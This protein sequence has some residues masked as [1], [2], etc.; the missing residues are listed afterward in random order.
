MSLKL[1]KEDARPCAV[2]LECAEGKCMWADLLFLEA[3]SDFVRGLVRSRTV[4]DGGRLVCG[5]LG[6]THPDMKQ[7]WLLVVISG[8]RDPRLSLRW[9]ER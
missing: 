6:V 9:R 5:Q 7:S 2:V 8:R 1:S 3:V 4:Q